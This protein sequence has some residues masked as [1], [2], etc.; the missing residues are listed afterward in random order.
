MILRKLLK[1]V[2][3]TATLKFLFTK[4]IVVI[5]II[6]IEILTSIKI[7]LVTKILHIMKQ[8]NKKKKSF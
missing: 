8:K 7:I 4:K 1:E 2:I 6:Q 5:I 3:A